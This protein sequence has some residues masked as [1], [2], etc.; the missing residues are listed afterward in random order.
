MVSLTATRRLRFEDDQGKYDNARDDAG[1]NAVAA[2]AL[3]GLLAQMELGY[4]LRS[5]CEL[6]PREDPTVEVIG[7]SLADK[8]TVSLDVSG[9]RQW[10]EQSLEAAGAHGLAW[11]TEVLN[12]RADDRLKEI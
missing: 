6:I 7:A 11:R 5:G 10:L 9:A 2:L 4:D 8:R 3:Y 12:A 1:R